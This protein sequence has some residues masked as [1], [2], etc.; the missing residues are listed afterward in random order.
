M[1]TCC[2]KQM[3]FKTHP[4]I[5]GKDGKKEPTLVYLDHILV[6]NIAELDSRNCTANIKVLMW[7]HWYDPRLIG[8]DNRT[9]P[10]DLWTPRIVLAESM[11]DFNIKLR[12]CHLFYKDSGGLYALTEYTGCVSNP[13]RDIKN[14]PFDTDEL[15]LTFYAC[16]YMQRD[17]K[18]RNV[19][20]KEDYRFLIDSQWR[21]SV[22]SNCSEDSSSIDL[23]NKSKASVPA[24]ENFTLPEWIV[25]GITGEYV[26]KN[27]RQD[28]F[29]V[30]VLLS[31]RSSAILA[32]VLIPLYLNVLLGSGAYFMDSIAEI[33]KH[34][35][36][37]L[38]ATFALLF[39]VASDLP[40]A[41][42]GKNNGLTKMGEVTTLAMILIVLF[43]IG[44]AVCYTFF[45]ETLDAPTN[46]YLRFILLLVGLPILFTIGVLCILVPPH[47]TRKRTIDNNLSKYC[48][49]KNKRSDGYYR[50]LSI[51]KPFLDDFKENIY[52]LETFKKYWQI[53]LDEAKKKMKKNIRDDKS[54]MEKA[55]KSGIIRF[56]QKDSTRA[57]SW[58]EW[59]ERVEKQGYT[60]PTQADLKKS[61]IH[62]GDMEFWNPVSRQE[63]DD[64]DGDFVEMGNHQNLSHIDKRC[65]SFQD[66][67]G[68]FGWDQTG[69]PHEK[70][71]LDFIYVKVKEIRRSTDKFH[72]NGSGV[73][74]EQECEEA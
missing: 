46:E 23:K 65:P 7:V 32:N 54:M 22:N 5:S 30:K 72:D 50:K 56:K 20:F 26:K 48:G 61:E 64:K 12:E 38:L 39:V 42:F 8:Y 47:L 74:E 43:G 9:L 11:R 17:E 57:L 49:S 27:H 24:S 6:E 25:V 71:P 73:A 51:S 58:E 19:A 13:M 68:P 36:T 15:A 14:F 21:L 59:K 18:D 2:T 67:F 35:T 40:R 60:F 4:G 69:I 3:D 28:I 33:L 70:K 66:S 55:R 16:E 37:L 1:D 52:Q 41:V 31:R 62:H 44:S 34:F 53:H 45:T 29:A 63:K 10:G